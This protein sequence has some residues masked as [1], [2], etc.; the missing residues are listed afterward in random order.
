MK[1]IPFA[2]Y[3]AIDAV[4]WSLLRELRRSPLHFRYRE[5]NQRADS[6]MFM[7][8]R[9]FHTATLE[10]HRFDFDYAIFTGARRAGKAWDDFCEAN[11]GKTILKQEE[12]A[13]CLAMRDAVMGHVA[14]SH[15]FKVG[16][17]EQTIEW[18]DKAGG[19]KCKARPDWIS[20]VVLD[21]KSS[22]DARQGEF[23]KTAARLDYHC[24]LAFY[25]R[26]VRATTGRDLPM[27][28]VVAE[29][30][31]P[32]DVAV[33]RVPEFAGDAADQIIDDLLMRLKLC[34]ATD[35]WPGA[36]E[37]EEDLLLPPWAIDSE[38]DEELT[39]E[40]IEEGE[41]ANG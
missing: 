16:I 23:G 36:H 5:K 41:T 22:K 4:N 37:E 30:E 6:T 20:D 35:R 9:G 3:A 28:F 12:Y 25:R 26:G 24:Q 31:A 27:V 13:A 8:G 34:R 29:H 19:I 21:L 40:V 11:A 38:G 15:Y 39:S 33:Y 10:P 17:P 1:S 18:T 32:H 7:K 2:E 14:A